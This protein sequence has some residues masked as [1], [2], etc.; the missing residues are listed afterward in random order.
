MGGDELVV[1]D[2]LE[3]RRDLCSGALD[4]RG[5]DRRL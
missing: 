4:V 3:S 1:K 5:D 2:R